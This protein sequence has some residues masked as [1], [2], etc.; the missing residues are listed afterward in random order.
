VSSDPSVQVPIEEVVQDIVERHTVA[1]G[2]YESDFES[3]LQR[4]D[5]DN[6]A[7][8]LWQKDPTLW[9]GGSEHEAIIAHSLGWL[10]LAETMQ[11]HIAE[12]GAFADEIRNA[13]F[14]FVVVL[15]M[16]GSSLGAEVLS[17]SFGKQ[18]EYPQL[19]V[20]DST[21][22]TAVRHLEQRINIGN[23]LFVVSSKSSTTTEPQM[24]QRY[25]HDRVKR[26]KGDAAIENFIAITDPE[27]PLTKEA[28]HSHF[29]RVWLNLPDIGGRYSALSYFGM[30]PFFL[31]GGDG[32]TLLDRAGQAVQTCAGTVAAKDNPGAR[33]GAAL[34]TLAN[35]GRNKLTVVT[36]PPLN[37]LG[38]WIEQLISESLGKEG[39]GIVPVVGEPLGAPEVYGDDRVF[40][41]IHAGAEAN[42]DIAAKLSALEAAGHPVLRH[43]LR[44]PLDLGQEFF[45]WQ[46]ATAVAGALL[47]VDPFDQPDAQESKDNTKR[48]LAEYGQNGALPQQKLIIA[49]NSLRVF[50]DA[51]TCDTLRRGGSSLPA[52]VAT[53]LA[54][55][56]PGDYFAI[57][58][59][60]EELGNYDSLLQQIRGV[61]RDAKNVATTLGY[62]PRFLHSTGQ[63]HKGGPDAG[64]FLQITSEDIND[65]E[66]PGEKFSFGVLKHAQALGDFDALSNRH[67]RVVRID[68]GRDVEKGLRRVLSLVEEAVSQSS[69]AAAGVH[70]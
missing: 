44:D 43:S 18:D 21:V 63:L 66:V 54:R 65:I 7:S 53:H 6:F 5:Q 59:Y 69:A 29:R 58:A 45:S 37:S 39:K 55:L 68:L 40:L 34:G 10:T 56:G 51:E 33:L 70:K 61:V 52:I 1:L 26:I 57:T 60:I 3:C 14:E 22:P 31:M 8:R 49:E 15:G 2:K 16:G 11:S 13:G 48:L 4:L 23:T 12:L 24:F 41:S 67:R 46:F 20:L 27:S 35:A 62:G 9:K 64:V 30:I 17:R 19:Y 50:G 32:S 25:F 42:A 36:S 47:G 38:L 28:A